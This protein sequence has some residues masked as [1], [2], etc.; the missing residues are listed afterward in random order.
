[1]SY[2]KYSEGMYLTCMV[3]REYTERD[4]IAYL[5]YTM[6]VKIVKLFLSAK[7]LNILNKEL[8]ELY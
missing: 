4:S 3:R 6:C 7:Q 8:H 1:M 2:L 5:M